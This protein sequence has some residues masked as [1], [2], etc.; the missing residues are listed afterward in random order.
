MNNQRTEKNQHEQKENRIAHT[1]RAHGIVAHAT[2]HNGIRK[3]H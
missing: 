2:Q 3:A 1:G